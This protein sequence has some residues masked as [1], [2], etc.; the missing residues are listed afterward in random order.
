MRFFAPLLVT[1][2]GRKYLTG[3][4]QSSIVLTTGTVADHPVPNVSLQSPFN[5]S[6]HRENGKVKK[7]KE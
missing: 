6:F 4:A 1:K 7:D 3:G 2:V 5:F